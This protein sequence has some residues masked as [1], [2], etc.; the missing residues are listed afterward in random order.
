[1]SAGLLDARLDQL[2]KTIEIT[3]VSFYDFG[4]FVFVLIF[5]FWPGLF[6]FHKFS[7]FTPLQT[8]NPPNVRGLG[9]PSQPLERVGEQHPIP[10]RGG[11]EL[12][13][14]IGVAASVVKKFTSVMFEQTKK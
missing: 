2:Q 14:K 4:L 3:W 6:L 10:S 12:V 1:M 7:H 9:D 13:K 8:F 11:D 5:H